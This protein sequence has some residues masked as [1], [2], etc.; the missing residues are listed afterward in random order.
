[1]VRN[2]LSQNIIS[3]LCYHLVT[4]VLSYQNITGDV[5]GIYRNE[6]SVQAVFREVYKNMILNVTPI[7]ILMGMNEIQ[8]SLSCLSESQCLAYNIRITKLQ[9]CLLDVDMNMPLLPTA[10]VQ[11][12]GWSYYDTGL[13]EFNIRNNIW[14]K[15][16]LVGTVRHIQ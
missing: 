11:K 9:C 12:P 15:K 4:S 16:P 8:C 5:V 7:A 3:Y 13:S 2:K 6:T 14:R 10:F 1:M